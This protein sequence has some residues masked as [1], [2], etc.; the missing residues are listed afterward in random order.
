[1]RF[2][3]VVAQCPAEQLELP[4]CWP[5]PPGNRAALVG[6]IAKVISGRSERKSCA[7][8]VP[9]AIATPQSVSATAGI[10]TTRLMAAL[11]SPRTLSKHRVGEAAGSSESASTKRDGDAPA[12]RMTIA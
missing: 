1:L 11:R 8:L 4:A 2:F 9:L 12:A 3:R 6:P 5:V 10:K 7:A